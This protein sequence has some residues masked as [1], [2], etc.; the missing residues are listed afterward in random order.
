MSFNFPCPVDWW[1]SHVLFTS[2]TVMDN[3]IMKA[4]RIP[5]L[6]IVGNPIPTAGVGLP[7]RDKIDEMIAEW[8][9]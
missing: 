5:V 8:L 6:P 7:N 3:T 4:L 2:K 9:A 1:T